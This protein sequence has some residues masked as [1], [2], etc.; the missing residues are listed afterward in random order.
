[1]RFWEG[2]ITR[3]DT[4]I[5]NNPKSM[6]EITFEVGVG[7]EFFEKDASTYLNKIQDMFMGA[8]K[9]NDRLLPFDLVHRDFFNQT[10]CIGL[11]IVNPNYARDYKA[12]IRNL[13]NKVSDLEDKLKDK[14]RLLVKTFEQIFNDEFKE[15]LKGIIT[16]KENEISLYDD[17]IMQMVNKL[18]IIK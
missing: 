16:D 5:F 15:R 14:E 9:N 10:V 1:M 11:K 8:L 12:K 2:E 17:M 13:E 6:D 4:N 7:E 18:K 3:L